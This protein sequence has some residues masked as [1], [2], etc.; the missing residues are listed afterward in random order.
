MDAPYV[1]PLYVEMSSTSSNTLVNGL[2]R[3]WRTVLPK[4]KMLD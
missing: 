1:E 2:K 3:F 4:R